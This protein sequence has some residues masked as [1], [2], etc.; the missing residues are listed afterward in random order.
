MFNDGGEEAGDD[1]K[2]K[3]TAAGWHGAQG[4]HYELYER[5]VVGTGTSG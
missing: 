4:S 5:C 1:L 3:A 2:V